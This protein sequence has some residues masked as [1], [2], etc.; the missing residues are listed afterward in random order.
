M[1]VLTVPLQEV[2]CSAWHFR[3]W[4]QK[5]SDKKEEE[6]LTLK[7]PKTWILE[8][9]LFLGLAAGAS[10][11]SETLGIWKQFSFKLWRLHILSENRLRSQMGISQQASE[12]G[13]N[14]C[15]HT[16]ILQLKENAGESFFCPLMWFKRLVV[17]L[18]WIN[19]SEVSI[20]SSLFLLPTKCHKWWR[21]VY[22]FGFGWEANFQLNWR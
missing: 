3:G 19:S 14:F 10:Y 17:C 16:Q 13:A 18:I 9:F 2:R 20:G 22:L 11:S 7:S 21:H 1:I 4:P 5:L 6:P 15:T 8:E 12:D